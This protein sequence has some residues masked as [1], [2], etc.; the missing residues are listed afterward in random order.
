LEKFS[1]FSFIQQ[2][3]C[4]LDQFFVLTDCTKIKLLK[5]KKAIEN[6]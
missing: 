5:R 4:S 3:A 1:I 6:S 2:K